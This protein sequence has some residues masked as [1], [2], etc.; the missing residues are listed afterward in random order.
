MKTRTKEAVIV[1]ACR[2]PIG[3]AGDR[4]VFRSV[5]FIDLFVPV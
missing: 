5:G 1:D 3:R 4:G 2:S